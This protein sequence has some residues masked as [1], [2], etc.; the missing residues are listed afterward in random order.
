MAAMMGFSSFDSTH[1]K[2][3]QEDLADVE[4]KKPRTHRQYMNR[5]GGFN[6]PLDR[7]K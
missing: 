5:L 1:A 3:V 4:I 7:I 6:R 2:H